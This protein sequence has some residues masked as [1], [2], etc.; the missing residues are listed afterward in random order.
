M[1]GGLLAVSYS[2]GVAMSYNTGLSVRAQ[3]SSRIMPGELALPKW[4]ARS[5]ARSLVRPAAI[6]AVCILLLAGAREASS[7][8]GAKTYYIFASPNKTSAL[9]DESATKKLDSFEE[10][11]AIAVTDRIACSLTRPRHA[12]ISAVLGVYDKSS[13]NSF[14]VEADLE[15]GPAEYLASLLGLYEH[16]KYVLLF[17]PQRGGP[18]RLW[19]IKTTRSFDAVATAVR[20][21]NLTPLTMRLEKSSIQIWFVDLGDKAAQ[22][23]K[24]LVAQLGATASFVDGSTELLGDEN[25]H[26]KA[27]AIY[28]SEIQAFEQHSP[29]RF[30]SSLTTEAWQKSS[31]RTCS[32]ELPQ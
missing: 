8:S 18:D 7:Q 17:S 13:E 2:V 5:F 29:A 24:E 23:P 28:Q 1:R 9:T 16:Q 19:I 20:Q 26:A 10:S 11:N 3:Q 30:S 32:T 27:E 22:R 6:A 31:T 12:G 14:I 21:R 4:R 15:R 25:D